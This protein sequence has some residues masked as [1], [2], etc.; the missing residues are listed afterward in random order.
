[1]VSSIVCQEQKDI[2]MKGI[3]DITEILKKVT[4]SNTYWSLSIFYDVLEIF[5]NHNIKFSF[6][7]G[8][9]NWASVLNSD[10]VIGFLWKKYPLI[11]IE[12]EN[13]VQIRELLKKIEGIT[14]LEVES[15]NEDLFRI[16]SK[17]VKEYFDHFP[18][19]DSFTI[20]ELWF[21][22]NSI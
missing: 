12:K 16:D 19:F 18:K 11:I 1:M 20:E 13:V 9:E 6:W 14:Y 4:N 21:Y 7:D 17:S 15:V 8:E 22:T 5:K 3:I 2:E 10:E